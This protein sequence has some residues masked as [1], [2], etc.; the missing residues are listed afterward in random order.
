MGPIR[1][2]SGRKDL[3]DIKEWAV[4][5]G[6]LL[7]S[8]DL[9]RSLVNP[10][11]SRLA[12]KTQQQEIE[13][14]L[15]TKPGLVVA[16]EAHRMKNAKSKLTK[17]TSRFETKSR[18]AL[19]GSPL[20]NHLEEYHTMINW[21]APNYLG[22]IAQFKEF[23][24]DP[25]I[26]GLYS[27]SDPSDRRRC[28]RKLHALKRDLDPK[29]NRADISAIQEDMPP[30]TEYFITLAL[31]EQQRKAYD[32]YVESMLGS[33]GDEHIATQTKLFAWL[34]DLSLLCNHPSCFVE[35][36]NRRSEQ[37]RSRHDTPNESAMSEA[38]HIDGNG[39]QEEDEAFTPENQDDPFEQK[40]KASKK[41][42][43]AMEAAAEEY[44][45]EVVFETLD[46]NR[47]SYRT[48]IV[49]QIVQKTT[50]LGEKTLIFSHS[51]PTLDFL[52]KM[53]QNDLGCLTMRIDGNT[54]MSTRQ[55]TTKAFN[56]TSTE[57]QVFLI[58]TKAGGLGLNLQ[59]AN[60]VI[61]FDFNFNPMWE[62]QA[63]GRAYR[64]GQKQPVFVYR[65][66]SGGTF[67]D[68]VNN[69]AVFKTQ[70]FQRVVDKKN[71][72][73]AT[74]RLIAEHFGCDYVYESNQTKREAEDV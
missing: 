42:M 54:K 58:S 38:D 72:G 32:T 27:D 68:V 63:I 9:F 57:H 46:D 23:Y 8:Y 55:E 43:N 67:E 6:V 11:K 20:N 53:L 45:T 36:Y 30:K 51:I 66:R 62:E 5:A 4:G 52:E 33:H 24:S 17:A 70:L 1:K 50:E 13:D 64:L 61:L 74:L 26:R 34:G 19:T 22:D 47:L 31:T 35:V 71:P 21:L 40:V 15:L 65:F 39:E 37:N 59:G 18:I 25:I 48:L 60:R 28:L 44:C 7:L 29:V 16:D 73:H 3:P 12:D 69:K 56:E 2:V 10:P 41:D 14:C 49:C